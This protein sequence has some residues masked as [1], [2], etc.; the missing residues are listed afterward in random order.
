MQKTLYISDLDGTLLQENEKISSYS[1]QTINRLIEQGMLFSYA[2]ARSQITAVKTTEGLHP[3]LPLILY[4]GAFMLD[5]ASGKIMLSNFFNRTDV[6]AIT[7]TLEKN[8]V[9][10]L[11]YAYINNEEK[12]S[13]YPV[14]TLYSGLRCFLSNRPNDPRHRMVLPGDDLLAGEVFYFTCIEQ[15]EN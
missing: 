1:V 2:T 4:N 13:Y 11:V 10:P 5:S 6:T 12:F 8:H 15:Y 14:D 9:S 3:K 7:D